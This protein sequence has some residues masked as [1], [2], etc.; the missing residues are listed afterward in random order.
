MIAKAIPNFNQD[1]VAF[2]CF[3]DSV[4]IT[5]GHQN[6]GPNIY[7]GIYVNY[8]KFEGNSFKGFLECLKASAS[9]KV[10]AVMVA[11]V[12]AVGPVQK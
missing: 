10:A 4:A 8:A 11:V 7:P 9:L 6:G 1:Q 12:V 3:D 2:N 5:Q